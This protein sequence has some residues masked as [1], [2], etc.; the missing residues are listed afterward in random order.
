MTWLLTLRCT[1]GLSIDGALVERHDVLGEGTG[2]VREDIFD[3][4]QFLVEG[5]GAC[6]CRC[7][8]AGVVHLP[9]PVYVKAVTQADDLHTATEKHTAMYQGM[10]GSYTL[11]LLS[12]VLE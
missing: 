1:V 5:G 6:L 9:V 10:N 4:A 3:L 7:V 2:L 11:Y 12:P 8:T